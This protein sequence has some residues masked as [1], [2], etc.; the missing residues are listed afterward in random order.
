MTQSDFLTVVLPFKDKL[1]RPAKRL[2]FST[3]EAQDSTQEIVLKLW[4]S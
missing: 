1:Y 4:K 3:E 2:L